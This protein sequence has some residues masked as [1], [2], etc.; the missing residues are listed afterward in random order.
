MTDAYTRCIRWQQNHPALDTQKIN[1]REAAIGAL[2]TVLTILTLF[3]ST[4]SRPQSPASFACNRPTRTFPD[5]PNVGHTRLVPP[6]PTRA[7]LP[8]TESLSRLRWRRNSHGFQSCARS[9]GHD[10]R[11]RQVCNSKPNV[12]QAVRMLNSHSVS[13]CVNGHDVSHSPHAANR[14]QTAVSFLR[15]RKMPERPTQLLRCHF[16]ADGHRNTAASISIWRYC[17]K[18]KVYSAVTV[19]VMTSG[20][21]CWDD[22][23]SRI[24]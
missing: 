9:W 19:A 24:G 12:N 23:R 16:S 17:R 14:M 18:R 11:F 21:G 2:M 3:P 15:M 8:G 22:F 13:K 4:E 20:D 5:H 7:S 6:F 1:L 10:R